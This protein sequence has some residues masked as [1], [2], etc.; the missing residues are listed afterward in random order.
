MPAGRD[1]DSARRSVVP[2]AAGRSLWRAAVWTGAGAAVVS[3]TVAIVAVAICWLPVSG[4]TGRSHSAIHAGLLTFLASLHGGITVDGTAGSFLPLGMMIAVGL[5]AWR[6]GVGLAD[7]ADVIDE[8]DPLRLALAG[9]TQAASFTITCLIMVPFSGLGTSSAPFLGVAVAG[10]LLFALAGGTSLVLYSPLSD[11]IAE[12][13]PPLLARAARAAAAVVAIYLASGALLVAASIVVHHDRV[14]TLSGQVGGGWGGIP[15]LLLGV[16]AA[17]NAV[18]A[19]A[20]YLAGPGFAVGAGTTVGAFSTAHGTLPA[21]P[22]LGAMPAGH[23]ASAPVWVLMALTPVGAGLA[24]ARLAWREDGWRARLRLVGA[25]AAMVALCLLVLGW[26]AGGSIGDGGLR[27]IGASPW[28][29]GLAVAIAATVFACAALAIASGAA[30]I[31]ARGQWPDVAVNLAVERRT[32]PAEVD[33][34][35]D[36]GKDDQLAG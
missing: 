33:K 21:F 11:R 13:L 17:P 6:A 14:Q 36:P 24:L 32:R 19:G 28:R 8:R 27:T 34:D 7:A 16:L 15:I 26:Q 2:T 5:G 23:G 4:P 3:A 1:D 30:A 12:Q 18:V 29:L 35:D 31:A 10:L 20:S 9:A 25:A 22:L